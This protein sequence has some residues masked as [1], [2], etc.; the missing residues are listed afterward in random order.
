MAYAHLQGVVHRDLKPGNIL[1][2]PGQGGIEERAVVVDFGI[3]KVLE[4]SNKVS[5]RLTQT[6]EVFGSP[7]YM[8]P[9][10]CT[11]GLLNEKSDIYSLGCLMFGPDRFGT[12][13]RR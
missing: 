6:G 3:A 7:L 10:Q 4:D 1:V 9:E 5:Q 8:S 12:I 13:F 11:G 2:E